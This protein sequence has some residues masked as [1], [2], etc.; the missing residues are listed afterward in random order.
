M[1]Q[2]AV[3]KIAWFI[4]YRG[5]TLKPVFVVNVHFRF[6]LYLQE[7]ETD[8]YRGTISL[9]KKIVYVN[10]IKNN[11]YDRMYKPALYRRYYSDKVVY[12]YS[13]LYLLNIVH[14]QCIF[15]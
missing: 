8:L 3:F 4:Y 10:I 1:R 13:I 14:I 11:N 7:I 2:G 5:L 6:N 15:Y 9:L 12:Q